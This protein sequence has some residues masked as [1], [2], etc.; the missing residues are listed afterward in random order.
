[1]WKAFNQQDLSNRATLIYECQ[2][3]QYS[4]V[5]DFINCINISHRATYDYP[6]ITINPVSDQGQTLKRASRMNQ[7]Q[8]WFTSPTSTAKQPWRRWSSPSS[9]QDATAKQ[10]WR[11]WSSPSSAP[12]CAYFD[13][14]LIFRRFLLSLLILFF[15]HCTSNGTRWISSPTL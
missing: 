1:M 14:C 11:R 6:H 2:E 7:D 13:L 8:G 3:S 9:A 10:P 5:R 12:R 15:F 4:S